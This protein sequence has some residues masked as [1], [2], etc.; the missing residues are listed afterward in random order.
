MR[1]FL[2][3]P[4]LLLFITSYSHSTS[5]VIVQVDQLTGEDFSSIFEEFQSNTCNIEYH[6]QETGVI[7]FEFK[8]TKLAKP[9]IQDDIKR[10]LL[11][12]T[13]SVKNVKFLLID[14]K[15]KATSRC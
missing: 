8:N 10:R 11:Q 15:E 3:I 2:F 1:Q 9:D 14:Q 6:C 5:K 12:V 4:F 13:K 7:I